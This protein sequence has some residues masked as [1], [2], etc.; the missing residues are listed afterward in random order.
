MRFYPSI[1]VWTQTVMNPQGDLDADFMDALDG[2]CMSPVKQ[3]APPKSE[4]EVFSLLHDFN[5]ES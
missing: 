1:E 2:E 4:L 3:S 5:L